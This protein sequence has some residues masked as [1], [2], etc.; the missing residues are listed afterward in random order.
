MFASGNCQ[1]KFDLGTKTDQAIDVRS[2]LLGL[3]FSL[4][5]LATGTAAGVVGSSPSP[6]VLACTVTE[7][8]ALPSATASCTNIVL[9]DIVVPGNQ[10]LNMSKLK[11][12]TRITFAG[13][14]VRGH[15]AELL[16]SR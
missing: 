4:L 10:T 15:V 13:K 1:S 6:A 2:S 14:T 9:Q 7:F 3:S 11:S 8:S 5:S 16:S 12:G